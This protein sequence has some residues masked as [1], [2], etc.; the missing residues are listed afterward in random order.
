MSTIHPAIVPNE[1]DCKRG[2]AVIPTALQAEVYKEVAIILAM[3]LNVAV[4]DISTLHIPYGI[5]GR[6][7][8]HEEILDAL[9]FGLDLRMEEL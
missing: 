6:Q 7:Y 1:R 9:M 4:A 5:R 8:T 2:Y 3:A